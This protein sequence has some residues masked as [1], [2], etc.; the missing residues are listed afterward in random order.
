MEKRCI[1]CNQPL[2]FFQWERL[3]CGT[4]PQ[5]VCP[6]C[7]S[8]YYD[9]S[10][11]QLAQTALE[12]GRAVQP[13]TVRTWLEQQQARAKEKQAQEKA[14]QQALQ[15]NKTCLR[16]GS[17]MFR[18]G[19]QQFKLGEETFWFSDWNRILSGSLELDLIFCEECGK[20]EFYLP[21]KVSSSPPESPPSPPLSEQIPTTAP[22][23]SRKGQKP[24]WEG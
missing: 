7:W 18:M 8:K 17:P 9:L 20:V 13:E 14:K 4:V 6:D 5:P 23:F 10:P 12:T 1:F 22:R 15:T 24:P 21:K 11:A 19:T 2:P 3:S 16:C